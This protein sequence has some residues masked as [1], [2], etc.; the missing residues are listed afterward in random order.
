MTFEGTTS[1]TPVAGVPLAS[2]PVEATSARTRKSMLHTIDAVRGMIIAQERRT[3]NGEGGLAE[4]TALAELDDVLRRTVDGIARHLLERDDC[5]YREI[6]VALGISAQAAAKRY[7][8]VS[9]RPAGGQ[10]SW[11][12]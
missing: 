10:P 3:R 4:L 6:G 11:L 2:T 9:S 8:G 1:R 5:S 7:P 12:R